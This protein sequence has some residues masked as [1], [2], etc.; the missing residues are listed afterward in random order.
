MKNIQHD[1]EQR[2]AQCFIANYQ[3]YCDGLNPNYN[4]IEKSADTA[5]KMATG[6]DTYT[7]E[8]GIALGRTIAK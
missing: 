2:V 5:R 7:I 6:L 3:Q 1:N 4:N 8:R